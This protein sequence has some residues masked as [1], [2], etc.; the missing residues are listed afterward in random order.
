M[1]TG[2]VPPTRE[3]IVR[4]FVLGMNG[5]IH[6]VEAVIDTGFNEELTL[7]QD[8]IDAL[9]LPYEGT[10]TIRQSD[11]LEIKVSV[12]R[13]RILWDGTERSIFVQASPGTP[14]VG[15][16]LIYGYQLMLEGRDNGMVS[17]T[18]LP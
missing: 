2:F 18:P 15:M 3:A 11:G 6:E 5:A 8:L 12:H 1:I 13:C 10:E 9:Q 16:S 4:L 17:L 7:P 14:L